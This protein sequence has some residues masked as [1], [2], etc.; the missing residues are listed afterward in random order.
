[1]G[2]L[3]RRYRREILSSPG[4]RRGQKAASCRGVTT[5]SEDAHNALAERSRTSTTQ[6]A[7]CGKGPPSGHSLV[8]DRKVNAW[9]ENHPECRLHEKARSAAVNRLKCHGTENV[10]SARSLGQTDGKPLPPASVGC[11][12]L[13][14]TTTSPSGVEGRQ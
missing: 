12:L 6:A 7:R 3:Q 2:L 13:P 11:I 14:R 8:S 9:T 10:T 5:H 1:M 4:L